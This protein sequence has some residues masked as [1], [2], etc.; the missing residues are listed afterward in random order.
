VDAE[1][2]HSYRNHFPQPNSQRLLW[3]PSSCKPGEKASSLRLAHR[4]EDP[5]RL[6]V[7]S[8]QAGTGRSAKNR[9]DLFSP[10]SRSGEPSLRFSP[11]VSHQG[12]IPFPEK[13]ARSGRLSTLFSAPQEGCI[14][15]AV[16]KMPH[17]MAN[18]P[19]SVI[20][21]RRKG[22]SSTSGKKI[23]SGFFSGAVSPGGGNSSLSKS[24]GKGHSSGR[25]LP[26]PIYL[27]TN[28]DTYPT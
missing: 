15:L 18:R 26:Y 4:P 7:G 23:K 17:S 21:Q 14:P 12:F 16:E 8:L 3:E 10:C 11:G 22:G 19:V 27:R 24:R 9:R 6:R 20:P 1:K 25:L 2:P 13:P 28:R 5:R